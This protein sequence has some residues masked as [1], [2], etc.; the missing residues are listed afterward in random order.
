MSRTRKRKKTGPKAVDSECSNGHCP[1][2]SRALKYKT[3]K[4]IEEVTGK[5]IRS[6]KEKPVVTRG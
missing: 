4:K 2:C 1:A 6:I 3:K 5:T